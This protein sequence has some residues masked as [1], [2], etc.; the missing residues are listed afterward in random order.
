MWKNSSKSNQVSPFS[1]FE[2]NIFWLER[3]KTSTWS[4]NI[5]ST[6]PE[7]HFKELLSTVYNVFSQFWTW[8]ETFWNWANFLEGLTKLYFMCP[9]RHFQIFSVKR[10]FFKISSGLRKFFS[11]LSVKLFCRVTKMTFQASKATYSWK[12]IYWKAYKTFYQLR[13]MIDTS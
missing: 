12:K 11:V 8:S 13:T 9:R 7:V 5:L 3:E 4:S 6:C 1:Y 2:H 10:F